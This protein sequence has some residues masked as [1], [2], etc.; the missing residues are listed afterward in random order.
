MP[1]LWPV[2]EQRNERLNKTPAL[3]VIRARLSPEVFLAP[4][5]GGQKV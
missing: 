2:S 1:A 5:L 3:S 4:Q